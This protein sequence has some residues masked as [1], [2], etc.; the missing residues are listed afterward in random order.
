MFC[1][2][3]QFK[4]LDDNRSTEIDGE[5]KKHLHD[6]ISTTSPIFLNADAENDERALEWWHSHQQGSNIGRSNDSSRNDES[7]IVLQ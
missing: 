2:R 4:K 1:R 5:E 6:D 3:P 7:R